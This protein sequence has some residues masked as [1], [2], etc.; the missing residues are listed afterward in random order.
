MADDT[1]ELAALLE[2]ALAALRQRP[3]P[4]NWIAQFRNGD[5]LTATDAA[6]IAE[7]DAQTI[8]RWCEAREIEHP[9]RP[10]GYL[11][12]GRWL[13]DATELL[14][15]IEHRKGLYCVGSLRHG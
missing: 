9:D 4:R 2:Q 12:G 14:N 11:V 8:R 13:V 3:P 15:E 6:D 10:L 7:N 1:D 5:A